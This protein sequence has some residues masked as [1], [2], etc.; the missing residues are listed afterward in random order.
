MGENLFKR[1]YG[2]IR[3]G[4]IASLQYL[5][6][7]EEIIQASFNYRIDEA[8]VRRDYERFYLKTSI[9]FAKN[10]KKSSR[11]EVEIKG[12]EED[13]WAEQVLEYV[14]T[15]VGANITIVIQ[16]H[17]KDIAKVT[18]QVIEVGIKDGWGMDKIAR[19]IRRSQGEI[20]LWKALRIARTE[21]VSAS[22]EG[23]KIG[24]ELIP[25]N[26][27]KVWISTFDVRS[28]PEHMEMDGI[29][30]AYNENFKLSNGNELEFPGDSSGEPGDII[31]CRCGWE[32]IVSNDYY[33]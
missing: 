21:V 32:M 10:I 31:N 12:S 1:M 14:R 29:R 11:G 7:P 33:N 16:T 24:S 23:V 28:R 4:F 27:E 20:D 15:R 17:Y 25:G 8:I 13:L 6:T 9:A 19:A 2:E 30:V 5:T 3:K 18:R 22:N 26:K